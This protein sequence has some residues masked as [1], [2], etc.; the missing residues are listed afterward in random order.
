M[1]SFPFSY[2]FSSFIFFASIN[3]LLAADN[4]TPEVSIQDGETLISSAQRFELGFFSPGNSKNRCLGIWYKKSPETVVWVANRNNP[5]L[6]SN[7]VLS[8][9][10]SGNLVLL[11]KNKTIVLSS[12]ISVNVEHPVARLLD[13]GNFVI[14]DNFTGNGSQNY[15][16]QSFDYPIRYTV[17][18]HEVGVEFKDWG[19]SKIA[20]SGPW[21]GVYFGG[22]PTNPNL[23]FE[24]IM[25]HN[26]SEYSYWYEPFNNPLVMLVK[27]NQS[28]MKQ[29]QM[30]NERSNG[31]DLVYSAPEDVCGH[32]EHCGA[33]T[34]C[35]INKTPICEC[36]KGFKPNSQYDQTSQGCV[37]TLPLD[38]EGGDGFIKVDNIKLPDLIDVSLNESM[39]LKECETK[40]LSN[41]SCKAYTN[42]N[43]TGGG[44]GC[45]MWFGDLIDIRKLVQNR[46]SQDFYLRVPAS[47]L[48]TNSSTDIEDNKN[49]GNR[50]PAWDMWTSDRGLKLMDPE[51]EDES[52][53]IV[54]LRYVNIG[55]L[56]VQESAKDRPTMREVVPMLM[57]QSAVLSSPKQPAFSYV[58]SCRSV[59]SYTSGSE[60][61]NVTLTTLDAR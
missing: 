29:W 16:W 8:I 39:S 51:L 48:K 50:K 34:V 61:N 5:I 30:W 43:A 23:V 41:C 31:W 6:E 20:R 7:G 58:R 47:E 37:R 45:L 53:V 18:W 42:S 46:E 9:S 35:S 13:T 25:V 52:S 22:I 33:N 1:K 60:M 44:S 12:N 54:L 28:G 14:M 10:E 21:N 55:L 3:L 11:S 56:C 38:C 19:S 36:L 2:C 57:N 26:E 40:C 27:L 4:I 59:K 17:T 32:Y 49:K 15:H 24:I